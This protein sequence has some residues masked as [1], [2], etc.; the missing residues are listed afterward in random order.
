MEL[1]TECLDIIRGK[2]LVTGEKSSF[3]H[4]QFVVNKLTVAFYHGPNV[5]W[6]MVMWPPITVTEII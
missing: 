2:F 6:T 1:V 3:E 4:A 5:S